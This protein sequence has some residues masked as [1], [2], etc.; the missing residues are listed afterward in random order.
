API[1][2]QQWV[3]YLEKTENDLS[4]PLGPWHALLRSA[5]S[6]ASPLLVDLQSETDKLIEKY[7]TAFTET[8][9]LWQETIAVNKDAGGLNSSDREELRLILYGS[10]GPCA[11]PKPADT[12]Y[13]SETAA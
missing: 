3:A 7:R 12:P 4:S 5:Q 6:V 13:D 2:V 1:F 10:Q 9:K 8:D 11:L